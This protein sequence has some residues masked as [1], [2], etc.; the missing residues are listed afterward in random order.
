MK[1]RFTAIH[2]G[3]D[4]PSSERLYDSKTEVREQLISYHSIN[5]NAERE[6]ATLSLNELLEHG[7]WELKEIIFICPLCIDGEVE[8]KL[9]K[10]TN[11]YV[12]DSCPFLAFD[13]SVQTDLE[14]FTD[15]LNYNK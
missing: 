13:Y 15:Y 7:Q 14:S 10:S 12:C 11:V 9:W 5:W 8:Y 4:I 2:A 1:Y 6:I 3:E